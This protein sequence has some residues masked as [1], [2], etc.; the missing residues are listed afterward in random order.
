MELS[1]SKRKY[2]P[3]LSTDLRGVKEKQVPLEMASGRKASSGRSRFL[4]Q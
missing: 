1:I 4:F 3:T 2:T